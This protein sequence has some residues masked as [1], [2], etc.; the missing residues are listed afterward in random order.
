MRRKVSDAIVELRDA[1]RLDPTSGE[2]HYQL[3]LALARSGQQ[4]EGAAEVKKGRE[5]SAADERNQNAELDISE[6]RATLQKGEL[7]EA[8]AKFRHAIKLQPE[9]R[10]CTAFSRPCAGKRRGHNGSNRR[11]SKS[12]GTESRGFEFPAEC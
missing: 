3:G 10:S 11:L 8:E 4:Q 2:A 12:S 7:Q 6:G 5:L 9:F 1:T